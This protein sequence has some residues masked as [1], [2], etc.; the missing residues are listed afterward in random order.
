MAW[1]PPD[2]IDIEEVEE[3]AREMGHLPEK[4]GEEYDQYL[5]EETDVNVTGVPERVGDY[6]DP[7]AESAW[8]QGEGKYFCP[9][10][11]L[12]TE[13]PFDGKIGPE[14]WQDHI[15]VLVGQLDL[16]LPDFEDQYEGTGALNFTDVV[17]LEVY[18][19]ILGF[20]NAP[21]LRSHLL[22]S[23]GRDDFP[24][25]KIF[26]FE[27]IAHQNTI[28]KARKRRFGPG[29]TEFIKRWARRIEIIGVKRR[30]RFPEVEDKR[31]INNGGIT[32]VPIELKRG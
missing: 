19:Q 2:H 21:Q 26:G 18:N 30:Y 16:V 5:R 11:D 17:R 15:A 9:A 14:D 8:V 28:R 7:Y 24:V 1:D 27:E 22:R 32:D 10:M 4:S 6:L 31:L 3:A 13:A 23:T 25:H 12:R 29:P 20:K